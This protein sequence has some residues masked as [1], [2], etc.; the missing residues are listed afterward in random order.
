MGTRVK[1]VRAF[2]YGGARKEPGEIVEL[3]DY[4]A[5][6]TIALGKAEKAG[7]PA[8]VVSAPLTT[9]SVPDLVKGQA[10]KGAKD[11]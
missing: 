3:D 11:A 2:W 6:E 7:A 5:R 10:R 1:V 9:E 4:A 8:P